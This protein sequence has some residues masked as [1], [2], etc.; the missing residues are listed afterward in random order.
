M[1]YRS[2]MS[3][4]NAYWYCLSQL[5]MNVR[6]LFERMVLVFWTVMVYVYIL[7]SGMASL[8]TYFSHT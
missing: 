1:Q 7:M 5:M 3:Q 2:R 8:V 6:G 4:H